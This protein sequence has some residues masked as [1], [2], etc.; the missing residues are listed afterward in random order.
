MPP[1]KSPLGTL[2]VDVSAMPILAAGASWC[3][4]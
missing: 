2:N 3:Y 1:S 4:A